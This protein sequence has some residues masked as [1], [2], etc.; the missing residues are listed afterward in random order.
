MDINKNS[1]KYTFFARIK[2]LQHLHFKAQKVEKLT[3]ISEKK[4]KKWKIRKLTEQILWV[5]LQYL[6]QHMFAIHTH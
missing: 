6:Q 1:K 5:T 4:K 2:E 3:K